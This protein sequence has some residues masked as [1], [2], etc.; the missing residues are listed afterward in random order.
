MEHADE[1]AHEGRL[2]GADVPEREVALVELAVVQFGLYD[3]F[4]GLLQFLGRRLLNGAADGLNIIREH[5]DR[6]LA[7]LRLWPFIPELLF[8]G[9]V[10][11]LAAGGLMV[12]ETH[13]AGA[14]VLV[15]TVSDGRRQ[16]ILLG[17]FEAFLDV[18]G[19]SDR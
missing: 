2:D 1:R 4:D 8:Q 5:Q 14:M 10:V 13:E 11:G 9:V 19:D 17:E 3:R 7:V 12:E 6:H 15:D 18:S 16:V